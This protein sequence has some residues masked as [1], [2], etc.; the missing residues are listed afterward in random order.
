MPH[1][2]RCI[3]T[4]GRINNKDYWE[5]AQGPSLFGLLG[6]SFKRAWL[7]WVKEGVLSGDG[8]ADEYG[9]FHKGKLKQEVRSDQ[10]LDYIANHEKTGPRSA[11]R[12]DCSDYRSEERRVGK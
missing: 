8:W 3:P 6:V 7:N 1:Y 5:S 11:R 12:P 9:H 10:A 2:T 4:Y